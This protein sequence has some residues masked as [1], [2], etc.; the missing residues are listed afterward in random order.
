MNIASKI[1]S[2]ALIGEDYINIIVANHSYTL[3]P[4]TIERIARA[5]FFLSDLP[6]NC[7]GLADM[8][9]SMKNIESSCCALSCFITGDSRLA[10]ELKK[11]TLDEIVEGLS[12]ALTL[13]S[14][15]NFIKLS[16]LTKNVARLVAR[17][18]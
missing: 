13:I 6:E 12:V 8:V 1:T 7:A 10:E 5:S 17:A 4:P 11:G 2:A 3:Y 15:E 16:A 18:R 14:P 9:E